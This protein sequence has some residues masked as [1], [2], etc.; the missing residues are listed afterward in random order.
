MIHSS[1]IIDPAAKIS[2]DVEIGPFCLIGADVEIGSGTRI[3]SHVILKGPMKIGERNHIF[4]FSTLGDG[5]PDKKYK[6]EPTTLVIGNENI[7]REGVTIHRGT[8]QDR[9]ET[10][11]GDRN[12]IMAYSHI[13]HDCVLGND[14][15]LTNQAALAGSVHVG[16]GAIL[17]G[18]AIVHQFCSLGS[19]S[20]CAMGSAVNKDIP[21]Y[22]KVRGNPAKPFGI[23]V[24]GIK[25]L[26]YSKESIEALRSAYRS[27]Y[28]KKLTVEE[29]IEE[30][31]GLRKEYEEVDL[32][33]NSIEKSTRGIS[34]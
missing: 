15:V 21:A 10:L 3:E 25:R 20:F 27:I 8:V 2:N 29:A 18:Y 17:G 24:T 16:D 5:S 30:L 31:K 11:I 13:A 4:Q 34:R 7:I 1:S 19:Y 23:N 33:L 22:V 32:F 12:L 28:R 6:N 14:I 9:G 26:G